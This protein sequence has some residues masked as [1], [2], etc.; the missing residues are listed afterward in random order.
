MSLHAEI[1]REMQKALKD[2]DAVKLSVLRGLVSALT[3]EAVAKGKKP[4]EELSDDEVMQ[5]I[6]RQIKQRRESVEQF[7]AGNRQDLAQKESAE[8][9]VLEPYLPEMATPE[10]IRGVAEQKMTELG[11]HPDNATQKGALIGAVMKEFGGNADGGDVKK[12]VNELFG[13]K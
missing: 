8:I 7:T 2:K 13:T 4:S 6:K 5:V 12:V 1:K 9:E 3:N 11:M 10:E